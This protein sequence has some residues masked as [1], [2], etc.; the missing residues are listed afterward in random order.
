MHVCSGHKDGVTCYL[1]IPSVGMLAWPHEDTLLMLNPSIVFDFFSQTVAC[2][3]LFIAHN[4]SVWMM[5]SFS[6]VILAELCSSSPAGLSRAG[7]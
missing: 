6:Q 7:L 2:W 4:V 5:L 1:S 3:S